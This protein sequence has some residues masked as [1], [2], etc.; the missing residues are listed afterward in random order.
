MLE[1]P[2]WNNKHPLLLPPL[3]FLLSISFTAAAPLPSATKEKPSLKFVV[4]LMRHGTRSP[5]HHVED[6]DAYSAEPWPTW[7]VPPGNLTLH[8]R[9]S[10]ELL[11]SYYR[12]YF[13]ANGLLALSGCEGRHEIEI[14]SDV[15]MRDQETGQAVASGMMPNCKVPVQVVTGSKDPLFSPLA[16]GIGRPDGARA[17]ASIA[18][19]IGGNPQALV[20]ANLRAFYTLREV[21][22]GCAPGHP[23]P[24]EMQPG[25]RAILQQRSSI[26]IVKGGRGADVEGPLKI[27]SSLAETLLLEYAN[28]MEG[29]NLGWGRLTQDKLLEISKIRAAYVDLARETPYIARMQASNLLNHILR[30]MEQAARS[31][32]VQKSSG[33]AGDRVLIVVG[34]DTNI[35]NVA[36][37]LELSWLL[38]GYQRNET[39]PGGALLWELWQQA[40]GSF[41]VTTSFVAQSLDQMHKNVPLRLDYPPLRANVFVPGCSRSDQRMTCAWRDFQH[42]AEDAINPTFVGP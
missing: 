34:H 35:S 30:S 19:R 13:S 7:G 33:G 1:N 2:K 28:G 15:D 29:R 39:P 9:K 5:I 24:A 37:M 6:L 36:G 11:G 23:C 10:M 17:A 20:A 21:L 32:D 31:T 41:A 22:F 26:Q 4:I 42:T 14:R 25:K 3:F 40:D 16:S 12:S 8:G 38:D 18:G 27:G